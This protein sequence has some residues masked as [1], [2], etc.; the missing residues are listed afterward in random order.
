[1]HSTFRPS[2]VPCFVLFL[3]DRILPRAI[4]A[5]FTA[6]TYCRNTSTKGKHNHVHKT[7]DHTAS[8]SGCCRLN[9]YCL[10]YLSNSNIIHHVS[11]QPGC[12]SFVGDDS[13]RQ[14]VASSD[15]YGRSEWPIRTLYVEDGQV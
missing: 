13:T 4:N 3:W 1:M 7:S 11:L 14:K 6:M 2:I 5:Y 8:F 15:V 12:Q 9:L 10:C